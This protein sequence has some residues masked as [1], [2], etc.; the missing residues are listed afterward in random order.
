MSSL[1]T[2]EKDQQIFVEFRYGDPASPTYVRYT[3]G[4]MDATFQGVPFTSKIEMSIENLIAIG[5]LLDDKDVEISLPMGAADS[6]E[7]KVSSGRERGRVYVTIW[8]QLYG[9][10]LSPIQTLT[11]FRGR[12]VQ[13]TRNPTG[14]ADWIKIAARGAK[15]MT[16][17][18]LGIPAV[19]QC[20]WTFGGRGCAKTFTSENGTLATITGRTVTITGLSAH[21]DRYWN[22]GF[23]T[24]AGRDIMIRDWLSGTT[25]EL[26][27]EPPA[28]WAAQTVKVTPG[29]DKTIE[30]CRAIWSNEANFGGIGYGI[31]EYH[32]SFE[33]EV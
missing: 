28:D 2:P 7:D 18:P 26:T 31:P 1:G 10:D 24:R 33:T 6:F 15:R 17:I 13:A 9:S 30:T 23:I 11:L 19:H 32:P 4:S 20:V 29:C 14:R 5:G 8:E 27:E 3:D 25:F 12:V 16:D 21:V 22:R